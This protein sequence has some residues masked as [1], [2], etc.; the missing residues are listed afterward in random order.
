MAAEKIA[1][2]KEALV[3][4]NTLIKSD[5]PEICILLHCKL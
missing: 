5:N 4:L 2:K 1:E 3:Q